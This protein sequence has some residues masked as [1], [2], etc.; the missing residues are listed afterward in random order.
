MSTFYSTPPGA[1]PVCRFLHDRHDIQSCAEVY[2]KLFLGTAT[3]MIGYTCYLGVTIV[4]T[5]NEAVNRTWHHYVLCK[6]L[7]APIAGDLMLEQ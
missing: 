7:R 3:C 4:T 6:A 5:W 1:P 2:D